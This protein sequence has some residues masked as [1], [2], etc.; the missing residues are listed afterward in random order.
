MWA[1][2]CALAVS[3]RGGGFW[4]AGSAGRLGHRCGTSAESPFQTNLEE[5]RQW[6]ANIYLGVHRFVG[7]Q[8]SV[9][10]GPGLPGYPGLEHPCGGFAQEVQVTKFLHDDAQLLAGAEILYLSPEDLMNGHLS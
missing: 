4:A 8:K 9:S 3:V 2:T 7:G 1:P 6:V 10:R 5:M